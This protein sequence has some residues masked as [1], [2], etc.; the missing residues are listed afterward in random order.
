VKVGDK[1]VALA[2]WDT[3]G[4]ADYDRL[5]PLSYPQTNIFLMCFS[6]I[7]RSSFNNIKT[8]WVLEITH[9]CPT[10]P[11]IL[12]GMKLDLKDDVATIERLRENKEE[13]LRS[14]EG[15]ALAKSIGAIKYME[16]SALKQTGLA[17]LF[18]E[19]MKIALFPDKAKKRSNCLLI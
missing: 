5:R 14:T 15:E 1:I 19:A 6:L 12:V 4:Q 8:K 7:S 11:Y 16:C 10:I 2:L 17:L 9:H 13:P 18:N 3:A